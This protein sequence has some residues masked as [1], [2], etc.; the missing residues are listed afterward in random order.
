MN[1]ESFCSRIWKR[2][3]GV[4]FMKKFEKIRYIALSQD[5][6]LLPR[7]K[8][9]GSSWSIVS[10]S[11]K[12]EMTQNAIGI[13]FILHT[14]VRHCS[15]MILWYCQLWQN[16]KRK[17]GL[18]FPKLKRILLQLFFWCFHKG[19]QN[20]TISAK[21]HLNLQHLVYKMEEVWTWNFLGNLDVIIPWIL[22][23]GKY[24]FIHEFENK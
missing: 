19:T 16:F 3:V 23:S 15:T 11:S 6:I 10:K 13:Y 14:D 22:V 12:H 5:I 8:K 17:I 1:I 7:L 9:F 20:L 21:L 18:V 2:T 4:V 24:L